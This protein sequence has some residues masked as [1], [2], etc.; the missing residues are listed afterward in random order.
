LTTSI[1]KKEGGITMTNPK[2]KTRGTPEIRLIE[3]CSE[4]IQMLCKA[5]RFGWSNYHPDD[6]A[7]IQNFDLVLN[8]IKDVEQSIGD[9]KKKHGIKK[10]GE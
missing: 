9:F 2:Y 3:E 10:E 4:L 5:K 7:K 1:V 6:A 8:E